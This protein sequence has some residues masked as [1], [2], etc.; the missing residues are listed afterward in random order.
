MAKSV[1][2]LGKFTNG[3]KNS[4]QVGAVLLTL[5]V[6]DRPCCNPCRS[7]LHHLFVEYLQNSDII[8]V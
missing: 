8:T 3:L 1:T 2:A 5:R 7:K 4:K 6:L